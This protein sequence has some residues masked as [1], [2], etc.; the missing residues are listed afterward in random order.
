MSLIIDNIEEKSTD[1]FCSLEAAQRA[2][3]E[4]IAGSLAQAVRANLKSGR[5]VVDDGVVR[6]AEMS[7]IESGV[8]EE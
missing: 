6:V 4:A 5:Y 2:G 3:L 8:R 7:T 1:R